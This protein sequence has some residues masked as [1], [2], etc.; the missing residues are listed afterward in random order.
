MRKSIIIL[1]SLLLL[2]S[3]YQT[4]NA[5]DKKASRSS[6]K[7]VR[8]IEDKWLSWD[9]AGHFLISG[10][11]AGSSYSV[12]HESFNNDRNSSIYFAS[13]FTLSLGT[14]KELSDSRKPHDKF[15]YKD[16]IFDVMGAAVGL[17]IVAR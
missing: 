15:S 5:L 8:K 4:G 7:K 13:I 6:E 10:I 11:L 14:G 3:I 12:Y 16:L 2:S 17:L 1:L 9:K